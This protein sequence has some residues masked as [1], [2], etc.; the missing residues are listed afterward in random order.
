MQTGDPDSLLS[1]YRTIIALRAEHPALRSGNIL[2][3]DTNK[4]AIYAALRIENGD[5]ILVLINLGMEPLTDYTLAISA[6]PLEAG[7]YTLTPL[8]GA[9]EFAPVNVNEGG[10]FTKATP[11]P[12]LAPFGIYILQMKK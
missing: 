4:A 3:V 8:M 2:L 9:G 10:S 1:H 5:T 6:S 7:Q 12:E 11:L